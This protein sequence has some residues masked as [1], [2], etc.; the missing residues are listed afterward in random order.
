MK[1][2]AR[3][4]VGTRLVAN[5]TGVAGI[6]SITGLEEDRESMDVTTLD[7]EGGFREFISGFYNQI[8]LSLEG[9]LLYDRTGF[10]GG[11]ALM[12]QLLASGDMAA[13]EI[14]FPQNMAACRFTGFVAAFGTGFEVEGAIPFTSRITVSGRPE[15]VFAEGPGGTGGLSAAAAAALDGGGDLWGGDGQ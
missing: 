5:G 13:F 8:D 7:S 12:R 3:R 4:S 6:K 9:F 14:V 10:L 15:F 1:P 11:Q 2:I